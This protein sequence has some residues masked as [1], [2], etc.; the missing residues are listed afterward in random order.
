MNAVAPVDYAVSEDINDATDNVEVT[1]EPTPMDNF[2]TAVKALKKAARAGSTR[3]EKLQDL[4]D[5]A[6]SVRLTL[7]EAANGSGQD[8]VALMALA[9]ELKSINNKIDKELEAGEQ[10]AET[11]RALISAVTA[12]AGALA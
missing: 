2:D 6:Q 11:M 7:A 10:Q 12:A 5:K 1:T 3:T 8:H 4:R 9:K